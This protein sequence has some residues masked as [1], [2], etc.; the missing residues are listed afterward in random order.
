MRCHARYQPTHFAGTVSYLRL[1]DVKTKGY[2]QSRV[3]VIRKV[4]YRL[5][6]DRRY[7]RFDVVEGPGFAGRTGWEML[8]RL[9]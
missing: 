5:Q 7:V 8:L 3:C 9:F 6:S 1:N 4:V 2:K